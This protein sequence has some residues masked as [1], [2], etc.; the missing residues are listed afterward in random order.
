VK[1]ISQKALNLTAGVVIQVLSCQGAASVE[2]RLPEASTVMQK[3]LERAEDVAR[4]G[5]AGKY[6]YEKRSVKEE[7]DAAGKAT[8]TNEE[9]YEVVPI[10]GMPFSRLVKV[11]NREL[12]PEEIEAQDRKERE[13]RQKLAGREPSRLARKHAIKLSQDLVQRY[14]FNVERRESFENRPM[15]VLS[16]HPKANH[17]AEKSVE[18]KLLDRLAGTLWVDEKEA[19]V[20]QLHVSPEEALGIGWLGMIATI[21]QFDLT[22]E[23]QRLPDG[24]WVN[25][26]QTLV[27]RG[28]KLLSPMR[29]RTLEESFNFR[30][31]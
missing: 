27:L 23:R 18:D 31:P 14:E 24:V 11:Q 12:T 2:E 8:K 7:L 22:I 9:M 10:G 13:F 29:I 26:E 1:L 16:F 6:C 17:G 4:S 25:K 15:L 20:A 21:R 5:E 19:E 28:R 30:K 3:V